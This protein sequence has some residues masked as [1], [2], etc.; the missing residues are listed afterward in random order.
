M[1]YS[2][3]RI[4]KYVPKEVYKILANKI[5]AGESVFDIT[6]FEKE[7]IYSLRRM[8]LT[9]INNIPDVNESLANS[10]YDAI[11]SCNNYSELFEKVK[12]KNYTATRIQRIM[13]Y[14]LLGITKKQME[15]SKKVVP[16]ARV[17]GISNEGKSLLSELSTQK[18]K[19][20]IVTSVKDFMS[21]C[22]NKTLVSMME[23]DIMATNIY[24]LEYLNN[25]LANLDYTN[26]IV[27][28]DKMP[29]VKDVV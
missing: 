28:I 1:I 21:T 27:T 19:S 4:E 2:N 29:S 6:A 11:N 22:T 8:T 12:S 24:T 18:S 5:N 9:E 20:N 23:T 17:L 14:S 10:I 15:E 7:I 25:S 3:K 16:Y 13:L 26:K